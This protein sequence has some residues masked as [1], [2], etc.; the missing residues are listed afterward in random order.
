[1]LDRDCKN[2]CLLYGGGSAVPLARYIRYPV[3]VP[4]PPPYKGLSI[5]G[6][7][8]FDDHNEAWKNRKRYEQY[9]RQ[10]KSFKMDLAQRI[11]KILETELINADIERQLDSILSRFNITR[12]GADNGR[13]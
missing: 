12:P 9:D 7:M 6:F 4:T 1:M 11:L 5:G 10:M 2:K 8:D 3:N 13:A